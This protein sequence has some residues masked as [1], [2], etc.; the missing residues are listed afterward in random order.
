MKAAAYLSYGPPDVLRMMD[1]EVP[2]TNADEIRVRVKCAGV[3]PFDCKVR[4]GNLS[5]GPQMEFPL[6]PGNEFSGVIDQVGKDVTGFSNGDPVLGFT[7]MN[8][9]AA[10]VIVKPDQIVRKPENMSWG[11]AGGFSG[12]GQGAHMALEA[13][14]VEEGDTVLIHAAAGGFGTFATQLASIWGAKTVIGT[15][16]EANH[17]YLRSLNVIP[18]TYGSGLVK[19][20]QAIAPNGVDAAIDAAGSDALRASVELVPHKHRIQ[21]MVA[22]ELAEKLGIQQHFG[23]RSKTRLQE[24]VDLYEKGKLSLHIRECFPL[25]EAADAH[26]EV[27]RGHGRGKVVLS[28]SSF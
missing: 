7:F 26:R 5:L 12:N 17:D 18:V 6:I 28:I 10:Y 15:A 1:M 11:V 19:R 27:E 23:V 13:I 25:A 2:Q 4:S 21:T 22:D 14:G 20:I 9:Y 16:S 24:L 8:C 3:M